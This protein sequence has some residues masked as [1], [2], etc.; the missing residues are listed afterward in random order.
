M[1]F[2]YRATGYGGKG[3]PGIALCNDLFGLFVC[4][5]DDAR[6]EDEDGNEDEEEGPRGIGIDGVVEDL[7]VKRSVN[8]CAENTYE[9]LYQ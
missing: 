9:E 4:E 7:D 3:D 1:F 6:N 8:L 5:K 2:G